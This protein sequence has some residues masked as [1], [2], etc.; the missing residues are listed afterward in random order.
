MPSLPPDEKAGTRMPDPAH[1]ESTLFAKAAR[2]YGLSKEQVTTLVGYFCTRTPFTE[3]QAATHLD[4]EVIN[5]VYSCSCRDSVAGT[6]RVAARCWS[7]AI[8]YKPAIVAAPIAT[9]TPSVA[10]IDMVR[11]L[12]SLSID[13]ETVRKYLQADTP[14]WRSILKSIGESSPPVAEARI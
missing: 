1:I 7:K 11:Q 2:K 13:R 12:L 8:R 5:K 14:T 4:M 10:T 3:V 6:Y 9:C